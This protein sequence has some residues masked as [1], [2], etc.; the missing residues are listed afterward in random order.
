[1][2]KKIFSKLL[3]S[4]VVIISVITLT[5]FM[6]HALPNNFIDEEL[7]ESV[8]EQIIKTY[9]L[10]KP[11]TEQYVKY[12]KNVVKGD[13]GKSIKY[14]NI[15]V[16]DVIKK[17]FPTSLDLG[18]RVILI[19]SVIALLLAMLSINFE[20]IDR[21]FLLFSSILVAIPSFVVVGLLQF[22]AVYIHKELLGFSKISI[23]GYYGKGQK[24]LPVLTLVLYYLPIIFKLLRKKIKEEF[25]NEY[26]EFAMSKGFSI[27]Y[28]IRKHILKNIFPSLITSLMPYFVSLITGSFI[29]ET[30]FG[31]PGLGRY[32]TTSIIE[33]DYPMIMGLT[34]FYTIILVIIFSIMDILV[35][36]LDKR[37]KVIEDE[38]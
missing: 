33:R 20:K 35:L 11:I 27:N 3:R 32:F 16:V 36:L 29:V 19:S 17:N 34:I 12:I 5:F 4:L 23:I 18:L 24:I 15:K 9:N 26:V 2:L 37:L 21:L 1:M 25:K 31:I 10:D 8:K 13:F 6:I 30:L 7:D 28:V 38:E 14:E 22:Y